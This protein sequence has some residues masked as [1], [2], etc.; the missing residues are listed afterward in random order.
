[1]DPTE[2]PNLSCKTLDDQLDLWWKVDK[3]VPIK[4]RVKK[5]AGKV[6]AVLEAIKRHKKD[7]DMGKD[8]NID[9]EDNDREEEESNDILVDE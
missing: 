7:F 5:K 9:D 4:I 8:I 1:L 3:H 2:I 6:L